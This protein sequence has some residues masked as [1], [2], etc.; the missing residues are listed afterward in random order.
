M[1]KKEAASASFTVLAQR[2]STVNANVI[3]VLGSTPRDCT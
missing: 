3:E 1:T 2:Q